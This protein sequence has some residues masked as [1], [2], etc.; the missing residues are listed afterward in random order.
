MDSPSAQRNKFPIW[1]VISAEVL[2]KLPQKLSVLEVACGCGVHSVFFTSSM[3]KVG[4]EVRWLPTDPDEASLKSVQE[5][6]RLLDNSDLESKTSILSPVSL[7]LYENGAMEGD[8]I[9]EKCDLIVC[10]NMI[11]ISPWSA[12]L[13][14]FKLAGTTLK[15]NGFLY[16]YGPFKVNGTAVE[17][18]LRFDQALKSKDASW[19]LRDLEELRKL[20]EEAG[21]FLYKVVE[22]PVNN[23]SLIFRKQAV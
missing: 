13:G 23:L 5:R 22:M 15:P 16:C 12:T 9:K 21:L 10:I 8:I 18:N 17:S 20:S 14:L 3:I 6:C 1:D 11:H 4:R 19:G 2:P 7:T